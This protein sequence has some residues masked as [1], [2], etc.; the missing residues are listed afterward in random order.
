MVACKYAS[1][2]ITGVATPAM[3]ETTMQKCFRR[4]PGGRL[5]SK[6]VKGGRPFGL[7]SDHRV[8]KTRRGSS[9]LASTCFHV[10][11]RVATSCHVLLLNCQP[12]KFEVLQQTP[13]RSLDAQ[14]DMR[15]HGYDGNPASP[16]F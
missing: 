5:G 3:V 12:S 11:L 15:V 10:L 9:R 6:V 14:S 7:V 13:V 8:Q 2:A 1:Q 4:V 16:Q